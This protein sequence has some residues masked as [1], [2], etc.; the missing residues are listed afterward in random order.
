MPT[1]PELAVSKLWPTVQNDAA[2]MEYFPRKLAKGKV[3]EKRFFWGVIHAV[4]PGYAKVLMKDAI[5]ARNQPPAEEEKQP[6][7][8]KVVFV[9]D[10]LL[11]KMLAAPVFLSKLVSLML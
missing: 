2:L 11:R 6:D 3:P 1:W 10:A 8:A 7:P 9:Q 5:E 4:K